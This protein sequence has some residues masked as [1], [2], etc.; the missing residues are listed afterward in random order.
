MKAYKLKKDRRTETIVMPGKF[1][2]ER[3]KGI[4]GYFY[5]IERDLDEVDDWTSKA[6]KEYFRG[7]NCSRDIPSWVLYDLDKMDLERDPM[8][9]E[10]TL[11]IFERWE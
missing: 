3:Y 5:R 8:I 2:I 1:F 11:K 6:A 9:L 7:N 4:K 10:L